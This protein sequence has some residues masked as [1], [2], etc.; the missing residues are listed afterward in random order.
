M[1]KTES[2]GGVIINSQNKILIVK[3]KSNSYSF[4]KGHLE[5]GEDHLTAAKREIFEETG[6]STLTL[7]KKL[8]TY[9]R[10]RISKS[11][12]GDDTSEIKQITIFLFTTSETKTQPVDLI[13]HPELIWVEPEE[14]SSIL[15]HIKDKEFFMQVLKKIKPFLG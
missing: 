5:P 4:P 8:G 14:V 3:Q 10:Y 7:I 1:I 12:L 6:I 13:N 11:G 15:T 2:A 9:E